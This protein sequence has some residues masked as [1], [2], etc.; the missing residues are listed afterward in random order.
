MIGQHHCYVY[1]LTNDLHSTF[2]IGVTNNLERRIFEH[3]QKLAKGF[4]QKYN[5]T[6]LV[7][8]EETTSIEDAIRREKQLK[9]WYRDWKLNLIKSINPQLKDL[10]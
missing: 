8:F 3:K 10:S 7:Y 9:N 4:T 2:Y 1:M 6:Y 5:L